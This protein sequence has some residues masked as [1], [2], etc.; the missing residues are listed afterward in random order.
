MPSR[1]EYE[2]GECGH[3]FRAPEDAPHD[4]RS[5]MCPA[6]GSIDLNR[7]DVLRPRP[8]VLRARAGAPADDFPA[9]HEA[10]VI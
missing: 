10:K 2:C 6:C 3:R 7:L 9:S 1:S 5:L 4:T 8:A